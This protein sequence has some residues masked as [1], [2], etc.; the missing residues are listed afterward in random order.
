MIMI[1]LMDTRMKRK[2]VSD[3]A[4]AVIIFILLMAWGSWLAVDSGFKRYDFDRNIG[5]F[6]ELA[7][8]AS[9]AK[10]KTNYMEQFVQSL[11][12]HDLTEGETSVFFGKPISSL[13]HNYNVALS[14]LS[15]LKALSQLDSTSFE[16]QTGMQQ[17]T[18]QEFCWFPIHIFRQGYALKNGL[19]YLT[20]FPRDVENR[21]NAN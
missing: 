7:D 12:K 11:Q 21:C 4:A 8:R 9:D 17:V 3:V 20:L 6:F 15:R 1:N 18:L 10:T 5:D 13:Q 16:Y 19:W 14:L 2:G